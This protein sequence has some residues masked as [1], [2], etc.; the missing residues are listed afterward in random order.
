M[1]GAGRGAAR[2]AEPGSARDA[3][4]PPERGLLSREGGTACCSEKGGRG[5]KWWAD[6]YSWRRRHSYAGGAAA[7]GTDRRGGQE[8]A[9]RAIAE[10]SSAG[11]FA[12]VCQ[13]GAAGCR[14][15][16]AGYGGAAGDA[17]ASAR[18]DADAGVYAYAARHALLGGP[19]GGGARGGAAGR[20]RGAGWRICPERSVPAGVR[21]SVWRPTTAG[22]RVH[23]GGAGLRRAAPQ[24]A[25]GGQ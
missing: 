20:L 17:G 15:A 23:S 7:S 25:R 19:L 10:R 11:G 12:A 5:G 22:S 8:A 13:R 14:R 1:A 18:M 4:V 9:Y 2:V 16:A 6:P 24:R 3:R 21:G